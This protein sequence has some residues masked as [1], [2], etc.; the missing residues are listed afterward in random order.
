M[1]VPLPR[2]TPA[3]VA[4]CPSCFGDL[5]DEGF[6]FWCPACKCTWQFNQVGYLDETDYERD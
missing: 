1:T 3:I 6:A 4:T 2:Y 5:Q